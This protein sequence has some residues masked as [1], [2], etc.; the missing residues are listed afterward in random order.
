MLIFVILGGWGMWGPTDLCFGKVL[1]AVVLSWG[2]WK[3]NLASGSGSCHGSVTWNSPSSPNVTSQSAVD[4]PAGWGSEISSGCT[5]GLW[6]KGVLESVLQLAQDSVRFPPLWAQLEPCREHK[7]DVSYCFHHQF[8]LF[9]EGQCLHSPSVAAV[10]HLCGACSV[11][12]SG[13][14]LF[15]SVL[16]AFFALCVF[17]YDTQCSLEIFKKSIDVIKHIHIFC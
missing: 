7:R 1:L 14:W 15:L 2:I 6:V 5:N 17:N 9:S 13:L 8:I 16:P 3:Q 4:P 12:E 11:A 10:L